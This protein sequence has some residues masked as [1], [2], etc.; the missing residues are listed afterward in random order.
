M[1]VGNGFRQC[2]NMFG[3]V[4]DEALGT[5]LCLCVLGLNHVEA[6]RVTSRLLIIAIFFT[7]PS[8][9]RTPRQSG[10]FE[11]PQNLFP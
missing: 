5:P 2:S 6:E 8:A 7:P 11:Q 1:V 10:Y 9:E 3:K 4:P